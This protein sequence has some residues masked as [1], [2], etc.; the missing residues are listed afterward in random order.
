MLENVQVQKTINYGQI[1][2]VGVLVISLLTLLVQ[3]ARFQNT[4]ELRLD[5]AEQIRS[6]AMP[7]LEAVILSQSATEGRFDNVSLAL[8]EVRDTNRTMTEAV[9]KVRER[10]AAIEAVLNVK[11]AESITK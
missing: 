5:Q 4:T 2:T 1:A 7:K 6:M 10:L 8:R 9:A 3:Q 11:S